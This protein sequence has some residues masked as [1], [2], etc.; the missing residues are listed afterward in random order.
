MERARRTARIKPDAKIFLILSPSFQ[1]LAL[2]I[3][4]PK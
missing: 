2:P 1:V 4:G 3:T